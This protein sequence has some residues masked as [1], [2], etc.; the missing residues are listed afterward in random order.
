MQQRSLNQVRLAHDKG[1]HDDRTG[2]LNDSHVILIQ[3]DVLYRCWE[4][5]RENAKVPRESKA[6]QFAKQVAQG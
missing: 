1:S 6:L 3:R 5:Y 2:Q 4:V